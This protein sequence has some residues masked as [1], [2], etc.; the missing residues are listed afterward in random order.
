MQATAYVEALAV[1]LG[2][3]TLG[4]VAHELAHALAL[5][6]AGLSHTVE[7]LPGRQERGG[8]STGVG[9]PLARVRPTGVPDDVSPWAVR[10]A[11]LTPL[12]LASPLALLLLG[13]LPNPFATGNV[14][15]ELALVG[16]LGCAIPSPRDFSVA[17]YP[18]RAL[19]MAR[20][21]TSDAPAGP[22]DRS[23]EP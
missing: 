12:L 22:P 11:A 8:P 18:D 13:V 15:A 20:D 10:C 21:R 5:R 7:V 17:W 1:L 16:W 4:L 6:A 3:C 9:G 14:T 19:A 23:D 2:S